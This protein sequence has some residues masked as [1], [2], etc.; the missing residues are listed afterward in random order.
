MIVKS[1][2]TEFRAVDRQ[3][4]WKSFIELAPLAKWGTYI[5]RSDLQADLERTFETIIDKYYSQLQYGIGNDNL[6][7]DPLNP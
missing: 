3:D 6:P 1:T 4:E 2:R 5:P 7:F